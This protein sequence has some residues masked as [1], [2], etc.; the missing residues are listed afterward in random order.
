MSVMVGK[1]WRGEAGLYQWELF[2]PCWVLHR[3]IRPEPKVS[4]TFKISQQSSL[5]ARLH[6]LKFYNL[7]GGMIHPVSS[8]GCS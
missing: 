8:C 5:L 6:P 7:T 1:A 2:T 4:R 3:E